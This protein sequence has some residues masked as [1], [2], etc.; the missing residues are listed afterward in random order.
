MIEPMYEP[1]YE[2]TNDRSCEPMNHRINEGTF[3]ARRIPISLCRVKPYFQ[4]NKWDWANNV[5]RL[6][7]WLYYTV[8]HTKQNGEC[9]MTT[10]IV[11]WPYY[12]GDRPALGWHQCWCRR[13][14]HRNCRSGRGRCRPVVDQSLSWSLSRPRRGSAR[15][16]GHW[17][18][19]LEAALPLILGS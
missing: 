8:R 5:T 3:L 18:L 12:R 10:V 14:G 15:V 7:R 9:S 4:Y 19:G 16:T 11:K 2:Q 17:S 1:K 13:R 6:E